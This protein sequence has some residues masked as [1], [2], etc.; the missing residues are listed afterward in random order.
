MAADAINEVWLFGSRARG[1]AYE[2]SDTD[3]LV[4]CEDRT[5]P[6]AARTWLATRFGEHVDVAHYSYRGLGR[7][8][9]QGS[10]FAWHLRCEGIPV[11]RPVN[12]LQGMLRAMAPYSR[13]TEDLE[14]LCT[15][16]DEAAE[17]L[18]CRRATYFD[19]GVVATAVRNAGIIMSDLCGCRDFSPSAPLRLPQLSD[20][21]TLPLSRLAYEGLSACRRAS[22]RGAPLEGTLPQPDDVAAMLVGLRAWLYGC[23]E[24]AEARGR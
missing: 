14:V 21:P 6:R 3:V 10:L 5:V 12:R 11:C 18:A 4:V 24:C 8:V 1:E 2:G 7:L 13:H 15:V 16:F 23:L 20:V 17:S 19:L 9:Q 22:E